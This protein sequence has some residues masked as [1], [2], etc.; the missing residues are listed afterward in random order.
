MKS[1]ILAGGVG[2]RLWPLSREHYPQQFIPW[3]VIRF[4]RR[5]T[6]VLRISKPDKILVVKNETKKLFVKGQ[7]K[8]LGI[9]IPNNNLHIES[10][11]KNIL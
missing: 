11:G 5:H 7:I 6:N 2:T 8:E 9:D 10:E 1:I 4:F 3:T